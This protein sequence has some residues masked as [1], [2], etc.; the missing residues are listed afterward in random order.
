MDALTS[1][2]LSQ[3]VCC[4]CEVDAADPLAYPLVRCR[5]CGLIYANPRSKFLLA[6]QE[7][8]WVER[9][10]RW[11]RAKRLYEALGQNARILEVSDRAV[12]RSRFPGQVD[13]VDPRELTLPTEDYDLAVIVGTMEQVEQPTE[14]LAAVRSRLKLGGRLVVIGMNAERSQPR[15]DWNLFNPNNVRLLAQ[16]VDF[17]VESLT[18]SGD[19]FRAILKRA[20]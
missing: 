20:W 15:S 7:Q 10:K 13:R 8:R 11:V 12:V 19:Q 17:Q 6:P 5:G 9:A 4:I 1:N 16:K 3:A 18:R 14:V 2:L